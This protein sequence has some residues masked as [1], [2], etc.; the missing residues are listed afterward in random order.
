ML[1]LLSWIF[2]LT[3][4]A[5][6]LHFLGE[7]FKWKE[8]K[9]KKSKIIA[10]VSFIGVFTIFSRFSQMEYIHFNMYLFL[11]L[12]VSFI[13]LYLYKKEAIF[14]TLYW[15]TLVQWAS[16]SAMIISSS[17]IYEIVYPVL[18]SSNIINL[19]ETFDVIAMITILIVKYVSLFLVTTNSPELKYL[20]GFPLIFSILVNIF[21][22]SILNYQYEDANLVIPMIVSIIV[23][24]VNISYFLIIRLLT[25]NISDLITMELDYKNIKLK[26]KYY[27][28]VELINQEVKRY[29]HDL[30]NH[31][32]VLHYLIEV[33]KVE[34]ARTYI[35][36]MGIDLKNINK[37]FYYIETGSEALDFILNSKLLVA[38]EKGIEVNTNIGPISGLFISNINLCTLLANLLDNSI[39]ACEQ[40]QTEGSFIDI[41][42]ALIKK[43]LVINIKNSSNPVKVDEEGNYITNKKSGDH[44]LGLLQINRIIDQYNGFVSRN[45]EN[46]VFETSIM[47]S[48]PLEEIY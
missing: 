19:N 4:S 8:G 31:L 3:S 30:A 6:Y 41:K 40:Y 44:G 13:Y 24:F 38:R 45:Y 17:F 39:E 21:S 15:I 33:N 9:N 32:N 10:I 12:L 29:K 22:I 26:M 11:N 5:I 18:N 46:N 35:E 14:D 37:G 1:V 47:L 43:N 27:E 48:A 2:H 28:E 36:Q 23:L 16:F 34:E 25:K 7:N 42:I 20:R